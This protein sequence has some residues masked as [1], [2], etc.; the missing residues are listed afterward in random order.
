VEQGTRFVP[1]TLRYLG[2]SKSLLR[3]ATQDVFLVALRRLGDFEGRSLLRTWLYGIC[4]NVAY[5]YRR[6]DRMRTC[7]ALEEVLPEV[8]A[9]ASQ[10]TEL[11]RAEWRRSLIALLDELDESQR[12]VFVLYEI[13]E[14]S[15][16]EIADALGCPLQTAYSRHKSAKTRVIEAFRRL[17]AKEVA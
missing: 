11:E 17:R 5:E 1:Q 10:E 8:L 9:T 3:D 16:R 14:L 2:V 7:G 12:V 15:M 6:R 13:E 4:V